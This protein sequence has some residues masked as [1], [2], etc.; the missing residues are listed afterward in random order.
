QA[1]A[2]VNFSLKPDGG[3]TRVEVVT[4][5]N[6]TGAVAQYGRA[7]GLMKEIAGAI[8]S[9]FADNLRKEIE[10]SAPQPATA[11]ASTVS[12]AP[13]ASERPPT[14][15]A[16]ARPVSAFSILWIALK[17]WLAGLFGLKKEK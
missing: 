13:V 11:A 5:L 2:M 15:A 8:L 12:Q 14:P 10:V 9:Q 6:M 16:A 4:D 17:S 1:S 3:S 7:S